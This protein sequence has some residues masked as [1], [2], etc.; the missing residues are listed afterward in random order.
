MTKENKK[1]KDTEIEEKELKL[2]ELE[3]SNLDLHQNRRSLQQEIMKRIQLQIELLDIKYKNERD[4]LRNY[5]RG[6]DSSS[7]SAGRDYN[8]TLRSI[9]NR[10]NIKMSK[11][12]TKDDGT[13]IREKDI[14]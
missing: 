9:E 8:D 6:A 1:N 7:A 11:Y 14:E 3:I 2:T 10:L 4:L 5:L 12:V 13:L